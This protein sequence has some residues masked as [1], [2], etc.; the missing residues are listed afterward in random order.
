MPSFSL[1][2]VATAAAQFLGILDSGEGLSAQQLTD[3]LA[4]A[5]NLLDNWTVEQ[6]R[7]LNSILQTFTLAGGI[8][9]PGTILQFADVTIPLAL[10][11]GYG[12]AL[13]LGLAIELA[14]QYS[15]E[16]SQALVKDLSEARAAA[17]PL[18]VRIMSGAPAAGGE[19][20]AG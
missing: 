2:Q 9:T 8:Y 7:A 3:A 14:P 20:G 1:T 13:T 4:A 16:P 19:S 18:V 6:V 10:P 12:R 17:S 15:M 11:S 5:N